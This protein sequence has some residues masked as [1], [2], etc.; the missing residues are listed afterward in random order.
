MIHGF[1]LFSREDGQYTMEHVSRF[2]VQC[3]ELANYEN[4]YHFKLRLFPNTLTGAAFTWYTTSS[5]NSIQSWLEMERQFHTHFFRAE[6][7]VCIAE[8]FRVT[9]R[10]REIVDL[11]IFHF[12]KMRNRCKI[13]LPETE[14][15][16]MAQRGL[17]IELR[18]KFH[19]ME[20]KYFY[21]FAT[22]VKKYEKSFKEESYLRKKSMGTYCQEVN[23]EVTVADLSATG[24]FTCPLLVEKTLDV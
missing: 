15:V 23:Q 1:S 9:P 2:T 13:H 16:K 7:K 24:T 17:Y 19:G 21:E 12:K 10:N 14:Y 22:K 8:V 6:P 4:F 11:F 3:G 5:R 20:F 18:K